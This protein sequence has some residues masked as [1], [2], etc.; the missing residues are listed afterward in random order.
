MDNNPVLKVQQNSLEVQSLPSCIIQVLCQ[1]CSRCI[2]II[3]A[4]SSCMFLQKNSLQGKLSNSQ[5]QGSIRQYC[6]SSLT[7]SSH[8]AFTELVP[9]PHPV[10]NHRCRWDQAVLP[11]FLCTTFLSC[12]SNW[13]L[14]RYHA[15]LMSVMIQSYFKS[16]IFIQTP[17]EIGLHLISYQGTCCLLFQCLMAINDPCLKEHCR[18]QQPFTLIPL[19]GSVPRSAVSNLTALIVIFPE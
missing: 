11:L 5:S 16:T 17:S 4:L 14:G 13:C 12:I 9:A 15:I 2:G 10:Y 7:T 8:T 6:N 19:S 1:G 3:V 18:C